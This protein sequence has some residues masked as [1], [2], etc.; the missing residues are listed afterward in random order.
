MS[1]DQPSLKDIAE[2]AGVSRSTVSRVLNNHPKISVATSKR[3][4][5]A[6]SKL[7]FKLDPL[8]S[9]LMRSFRTHGQFSKGTVIGWINEH[10]DVKYWSNVPFKK[11][12]LEGAVTRAESMGLRIE[13]IWISQPG[14]TG[15]RCL[16]ILNSRNI[17][18]LIFPTPR[19]TLE[20]YDFQWN[21]FA[22]SVLGGRPD[23]KDY[24]RISPDEYANF[25]LLLEKM[26]SLGHS[27]I[28]LVLNATI[29]W[30]TERKL[31]ARFMLHNSNIRSSNRIPILFEKDGDDPCSS[32]Q[33]W[34]RKYKPDGILVF[35]GETVK[36]LTDA[37]YRIPEDLSV[38][39]FNVTEHTKK[40]AGI[41]PNQR[42]MG[43]AA[44]D[45]VIAMLGRFE[46]GGS[47]SSKNIVLRGRWQD[48]YTVCPRNG[49]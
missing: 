49:K 30:M 2:I 14:M 16:Q 45:A 42:Q 39:N 32:L 4:R 17:R 12:F 5:D 36:W 22:L 8:A 38:A 10:D 13:P 37:G 6:V 7:G 18:G 27:R 11:N 28:G 21:S 29:D 24:T 43:A 25:E 46:Y 26:C 9:S 1:K 41:R 33:K 3:V 31:Q 35:H 34:V 23:V 47:P 19:H 20:S 48:G 15:K 44:L 40:W